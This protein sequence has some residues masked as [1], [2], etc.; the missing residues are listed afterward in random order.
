MGNIDIDTARVRAAAD[1]TQ[2]LSRAVM[3]RLSHSLDTSDDVYGSHYGNGWE[4]PVQLK[5][6]AEKWE[7]HMV[8]LARSMGELSE[9]LRSSA[10]GYDSADAEAESRLRAG[11]NDLGRA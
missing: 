9:Q 11:L 2:S 4:S 5:V 6:C 7:E 8:S 3:K 1:D 10:D